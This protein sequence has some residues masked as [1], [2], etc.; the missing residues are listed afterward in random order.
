M[1]KREEMTA[2]AIGTNIQ[3][4]KRLE[5]EY[6]DFCNTDF[7][8]KISGRELAM[9]I[10]ASG[11]IGGS[12]VTCLRGKD[13]FHYSNKILLSQEL[14][15]KLSESRTGQIIFSDIQF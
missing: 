11:E 5:K 4:K 13:D 3:N 12:G 14:Y 10:I 15:N 2:V 1:I 6:E 9:L 8:L 7:A